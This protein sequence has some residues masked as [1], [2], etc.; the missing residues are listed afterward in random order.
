MPTQYADLHI[1]TTASDGSFS[2]QEVVLNAHERGLGAIALTDHDSVAAIVPAK[3]FAQEY[4]IEIIPGVELSAEAN[5]DEIHILGYFIDINAGW[6]LDK[7]T[8]LRQE[9]FIRAKNIIAKL[10]QIGIKISL[11][12]VL[13][14]AG[15]GAVGRLHIAKVLLEKKYACSIG[16]IFKKYIGKGKPA[17]IPKYRL[18]PEEVIQIISRLGGIPVL[19]HP[20]VTNIDAGI[21]ELVSYGLRGI[22]VYHSEH[23]TKGINHYLAIA[24][25]HK[26]LVTGGSDCHGQIKGKRLMGK[27]KIPYQLV[28][29]MKQEVEQNAATTN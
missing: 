10:D 5:G 17:Y 11:E 16:G 18:R 27:I 15:P 29:N 2:P 19:A 24:E 4:D 23:S 12:E 20:Q 7:L 6:F 22:E 1:H 25:K 28:T 14:I 26:L 8:L 3:Q 13:E 9:R 21:P